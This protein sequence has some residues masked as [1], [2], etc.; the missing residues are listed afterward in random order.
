MSGK[1]KQRTTVD[2]EP[3]LRLRFSRLGEVHALPPPPRAVTSRGL[4]WVWTEQRVRLRLDWIATRGFR[5]E[6]GSGRTVTGLDGPGRASD[7]APIFAD[8]AL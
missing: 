5:H 3:T 6:R 2:D 8:L 4:G 7:H 1:S